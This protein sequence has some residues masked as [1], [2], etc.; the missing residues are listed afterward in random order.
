M[1]YGL[2]PII[3]VD[4]GRDTAP[5][6]SAGQLYMFWGLLAEYFIILSHLLLCQFPFTA[7]SRN[8]LINDNDNRMVALQDLVDY[9]NIQIF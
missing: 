7:V 5:E 1:F 6:I 4:R 8:I 3:S 2:V 9:Q